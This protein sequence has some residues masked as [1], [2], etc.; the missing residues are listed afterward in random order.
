MD[1]GASLLES[2]RCK[3]ASLSCAF[4]WK[5]VFVRVRDEAKASPRG[6]TVGG[7]GTL[8]TWRKKNGTR[9]VPMACQ[10]LTSFASSVLRA[11]SWQRRRRFFQT[12]ARCL[13]MA[14]LPG[15][16]EKSSSGRKMV[17]RLTSIGK[18]ERRKEKESNTGRSFPSSPV[19]RRHRCLGREKFP[20]SCCCLMRRWLVSSLFMRLS[21]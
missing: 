13:M 11:P 5:D 18:G 6:I 3:Q 1:G 10:C 19:P 17:A 16:G 20:C 21:R 9:R 12:D 2:R 14:L 8:P 15:D 7:E 4:R